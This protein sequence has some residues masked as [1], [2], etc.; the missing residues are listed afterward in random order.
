MVAAVS[1][2]SLE[3]EYLRLSFNSQGELVR[4]VDKETNRDIMTGPVIYFACI[5]MFPVPGMPGIVDSMGRATTCSDRRT[6]Q[7]GVIPGNPLW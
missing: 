4:L 5:K 1:P 2:D 6:R 3:N 7:H